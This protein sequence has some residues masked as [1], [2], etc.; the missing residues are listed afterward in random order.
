MTGDRCISRNNGDSLERPDS[1]N[2]HARALNYSDQHTSSCPSPPSLILVTSPAHDSTF[3]SCTCRPRAVSHCYSLLRFFFFCSAFFRFSRLSPGDATPSFV[4]AL[5]SETRASIP[6]YGY[7]TCYRPSH[8]SL[9]HTAS[10]HSLLL[11]RFG[12]ARSVR[13]P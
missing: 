4:G 1:T 8:A 13:T 5:I 11:L 10:R 7:P 6:A 2:A 3:F 12:V 9:R